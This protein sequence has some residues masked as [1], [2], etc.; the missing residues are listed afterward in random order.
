MTASP[1][2]APGARNGGALLVVLPCL[3]LL[4]LMV[5]GALAITTV[6]TADDG[7]RIRRLTA[8]LAAES[9]VRLALHRVH[10]LDADTLRP[11]TSIT[12]PGFTAESTA[13]RSTATIHA[14]EGGRLV[15]IGTST[16]DGRPASRTAAL[17]HVLTADTLWSLFRAGVHADG[18][19]DVADAATIT[20]SASTST[21]LPAECPA[22]AERAAE[23]ATA[24]IVPAILLP[25]DRTVTLAPLARVS[26][27]PP[28]QQEV[29]TRRT[30]TAALSI[31]LALGA[32]ADHSMPGAIVTPRPSVLASRC[33]TLDPVN[34]GDPAGITACAEHRPLI[35]VDG[36]LHISGGIGQGFLVID[37][38]VRIDGHARFD[39]A[40][41][42]TGNATI[43]D[44]VITG[45]IRSLGT[46]TTRIAGSITRDIC[47]LWRALSA[48]AP[49]QAFRRTDSRLWLPM[50]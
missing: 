5:A 45:S 4:E 21:E 7:T 38:N 22:R 47:T 49:R 37:G 30:R 42:A 29:D 33:V 8:R 12:T 10:T 2:R 34:W 32:L 28:V 18:D 17:V 20:S 27:S 40:I 16:I 39:G 46:D 48:P 9:T 1:T 25:A 23:R 36:D 19:V 50:D 14:L 13:I 15:T 31:A 24:A 11:G 44:A 6:Q 41:L 3:L 26:G 35:H 43:G